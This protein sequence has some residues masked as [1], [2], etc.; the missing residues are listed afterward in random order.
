MR[1]PVIILLG[2]LLLLSVFWWQL[3]VRIYIKAIQDGFKVDKVKDGVNRLA[4]RQ[5]EDDKE[6]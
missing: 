1:M 6:D 4:G 2:I 3:L 5:K